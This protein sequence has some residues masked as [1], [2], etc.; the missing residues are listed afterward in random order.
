VSIYYQNGFLDPSH[1]QLGHHDRV[2]F[3][4]GSPNW[5]GL[6]HKE[7]T[8]PHLGVSIGNTPSQVTNSAHRYLQRQT[9]ITSE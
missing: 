5:E 1:R 3:Y 7:V 6:I 4:E 2:T 8:E 9:L